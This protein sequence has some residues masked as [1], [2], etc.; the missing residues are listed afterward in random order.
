MLNDLFIPNRAVLNTLV[1][2][3]GR[4]D[5][6]TLEFDRRAIEDGDV[7]YDPEKQTLT[8]SNLPEELKDRLRGEYGDA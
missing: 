6:W 2:F 7:R 5:H 8:V 1:R 3:K 4:T